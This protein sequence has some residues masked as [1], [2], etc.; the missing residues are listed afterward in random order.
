MQVPPSLGRRPMR[1]TIFIFLYVALIAGHPQKQY[2]LV[3]PLAPQWP[4]LGW[5]QVVVAT[6]PALKPFLLRCRDQAPLHRLRGAHLSKKLQPGHRGPVPFPS[7][8]RAPHRHLSTGICP[9][10]HVKAKPGPLRVTTQLS[11]SSS[12]SLLT[13]SRQILYS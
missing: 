5:K 11:S 9:L 3:G 10:V 12:P 7:V 4:V 8:Q 1:R 6:D 13:C 2:L